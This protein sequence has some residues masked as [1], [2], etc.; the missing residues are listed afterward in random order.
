MKLD[1]ERLL[2]PAVRNAVSGM[3]DSFISS[4]GPLFE[5]F[6]NSEQDQ[7]KY[8]GWAFDLSFYKAPHNA[9]DNYLSALSL[10]TTDRL[11]Y[12]EGK[13]DCTFVIPGKGIIIIHLH[14]FLWNY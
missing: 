3:S 4:V 12:S 6:L 10:E 5:S 14:S 7:D 2:L 9:C 11:F 13:V 1:N 8:N